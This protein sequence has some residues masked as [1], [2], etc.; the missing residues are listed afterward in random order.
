MSVVFFVLVLYVALQAASSMWDSARTPGIVMNSGALS[1]TV[2]VP[3]LYTTNLDGLS[4][5]ALERT[6]ANMMDSCDVVS[7]FVP[8]LYAKT[9]Q[10]HPTQTMFETFSVPAMNVSILASL[11]FCIQLWKVSLKSELVMILTLALV[12]RALCSGLRVLSP[13][14]PCL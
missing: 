11:S 3:A 4:L 12:T 9:F 2:N 8:M 6:T 5:F 13:R 10:E 14:T 7:H 1:V